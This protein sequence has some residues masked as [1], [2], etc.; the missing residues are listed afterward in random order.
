MA[1]D[2]NAWCDGASND[3]SWE[4]ASKKDSDLKKVIQTHIFSVLYDPKL[5]HYGGF[6]VVQAV[7][8]LQ[9]WAL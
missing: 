1:E 3:C 4:D 9:Y 7:K 5:V 8:L 2:D 6:V